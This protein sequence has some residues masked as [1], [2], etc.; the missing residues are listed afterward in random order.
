MIRFVCS[1]DRPGRLAEGG[2]EAQSWK[3]G[4]R[5]DCLGFSLWRYKSDGAGWGRPGAHQLNERVRALE[6]AQMASPLRV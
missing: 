3:Q 1:E 4:I 6:T 5:Q 2:L